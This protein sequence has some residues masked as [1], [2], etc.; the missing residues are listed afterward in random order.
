MS[1]LPF[2]IRCIFI[3]AEPIWN[4]GSFV[5]LK[6]SRKQLADP[7]L[8]FKNLVPKRSVSRFLKSTN[9]IWITKKNQYSEIGMGG[10]QAN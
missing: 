9:G 4:Q 1:I 6:V 10:S 7:P 3:L 8:H 2:F 5:H